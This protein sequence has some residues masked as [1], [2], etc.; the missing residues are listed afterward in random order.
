MINSYHIRRYVLPFFTLNMKTADSSESL[1]HIY[2]TTRRYIPEDRNVN[3]YVTENVKQ[4]SSNVL[5]HN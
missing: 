4:I 5:N 3:T 1:V 2:Q